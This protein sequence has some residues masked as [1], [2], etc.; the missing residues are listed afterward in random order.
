VKNYSAL[1]ILGTM[2]PVT[3]CQVPAHLCR[4]LGA[5]V[6][7]QKVTINFVMPVHVCVSMEQFYSHWM[8]F[9]ET[10]YSSFFENLSTK[11]KFY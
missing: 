9:D 4:F 2:C 11:L 5:F 7:F 6:K 3:Q 1:K 10:G 8:D